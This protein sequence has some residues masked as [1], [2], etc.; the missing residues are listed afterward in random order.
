MCI[1]DSLYYLLAFLS[2]HLRHVAAQSWSRD[3]VLLSAAD[4]TCPAG[5]HGPLFNG[6]Q[7]SIVGKQEASVTAL[8]NNTPMISNILPNTTVH[9]EFPI[10]TILQSRENEYTIDDSINHG[11]ELRKRQTSS[12]NVYITINT[13]LQ[14]TFADNKT[15]ADPP[16]LT[17]WVSQ[18]DRNQFPGPA[19]TQS[20]QQ[21]SLEGGYANITLEDV[22]NNVYVGVAADNSNVT[23]GVWNY[24]IAV[25]IDENYHSFI[26]GL[27]G[28]F[29]S[30]SDPTAALLVTKNLS[31]ALP[32]GANATDLAPQLSLFVYP[33][34][35]TTPRGLERS[36]CGLQKN[37][38][39]Q[40]IL[41][42][43][44]PGGIETLSLIHI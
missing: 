9:Y 24:E 4:G 5:D 14:P 41:P 13:C 38:K 6:V 3:D 33:S 39:F 16:Q 34:D 28:L 2:I 43:I 29:M 22:Q 1:R 12:A 15:Q 21:V 35:D 7:R 10:T 19:S 27:P 18:S 11:E 37:A 32:A 20:A 42:N 25:S 8:D 23:S 26:T 17:L 44:S 36:F 30:D 31:A 40:G